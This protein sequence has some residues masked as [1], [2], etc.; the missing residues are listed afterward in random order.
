MT[1]SSL[2]LLK[3]VVNFL[4]VSCL[5]TTLAVSYRRGTWYILDLF[6][7]P[8]DKFRSAWVTFPVSFGIIFLILLIEDYFKAFLNER[9]AKKVLYLAIFYPLSFVIVNSWRGLWMLLDYYTTASLT[10]GYA[11]HTIGFFIVL[12]TKTASS[13]ISLPGYCISERN[14]DPSLNILETKNCFEIKMFRRW[15][16]DKVSDIT[17]RMLNSFVTVF[18]IGSGV[19]CYWRGTW[20]IVESIKPDDN[21]MSSIIALSLGFAS[22]SICYCFSEV[23][24]TKKLNPP[25]RW[26]LRV[27]EGM[28]VYFL[29]FGVVSTW[30]GLWFLEDTYL[31]PGRC[32]ICLPYFPSSLG[33]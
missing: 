21:L 10:S 30:V 3:R 12:S 15:A 18:V 8:R 16:S 23:I 14:V 25:Y 24:A 26:W 33:T 9:K 22:W 4:L 31:F 29:G 20:I 32:F 7:F 13:I 17:T 27:M 19:I 2:F 28:F 5:L 6:V 11:S 1:L